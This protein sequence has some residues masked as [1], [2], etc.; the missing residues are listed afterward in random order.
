VDEWIG[1]GLAEMDFCR[2]VNIQCVP[3]DTR[4]FGNIAGYRVRRAPN[5]LVLVPSDND[6]DISVATGVEGPNERRTFWIG[7]TD[8]RGSFHTS[9]HAGWRAV[10]FRLIATVR[11]AVAGPRRQ[12]LRRNGR[13]RDISHVRDQKD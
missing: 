7:C 3:D 1:Q 8:R 9:T 11:T 2:A 4:H 12:P 6:E 10:D 5:G 13:R